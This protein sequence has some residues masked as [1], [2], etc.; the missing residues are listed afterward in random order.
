MCFLTIRGQIL[1]NK[2]FGGRTLKGL[3]LLE[4]LAES[5]PQFIFTCY[6]RIHL[7]PG[8]PSIFGIWI[9]EWIPTV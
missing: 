1:K 5:M 4:V 9:G 2:Q 3:Q 8:E 7:G 6:I